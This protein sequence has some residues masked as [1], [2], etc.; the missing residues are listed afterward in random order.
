MDPM[1]PCKPGICLHLAPVH[2]RTRT[3]RSPYA[4]NVVLLYSQLHQRLQSV[5]ENLKVVTN[6]FLWEKPHTE[7]CGVVFVVFNN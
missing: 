7:M 5:A 3:A 2:H 6:T 4:H 1:D